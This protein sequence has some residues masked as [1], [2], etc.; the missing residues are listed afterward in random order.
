MVEL[1][2]SG[3]APSYALTRATSTPVLAVATDA[4]LLS[5]DFL[6][7]VADKIAS[8]GLSRAKTTDWLADTVYSWRGLI[9]DGAGR[10]IEIHDEIFDDAYGRDT[11]FSWNSSVKMF[12][13]RRPLRRSK[14]AML[15]RLQ[16]WDAA[17][18]IAGRPIVLPTY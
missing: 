4:D 8:L 5:H 16:L 1:L 17:F 2:S 18:K 7:A 13:D 11:W 3:R 12:R 10:V 9:V 14:H 15:L 6:M